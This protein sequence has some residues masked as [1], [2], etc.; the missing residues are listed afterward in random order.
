MRKSLK[1]AGRSLLFEIQDL[2]VF[3]LYLSLGAPKKGGV[4]GEGGLGVF[5]VWG[6]GGLGSL[7][8][9]IRVWGLRF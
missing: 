2:F 7:E 4:G 6:F 1:R 9:G 3:L 8:L 5:G